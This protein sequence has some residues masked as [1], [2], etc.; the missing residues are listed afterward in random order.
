MVAMNMPKAVASAV[1]GCA[2]VSMAPQ[3][4]ATSISVKVWEGV[5]TA[6][7]GGADEQ[8]RPSN[9]LAGATPNAAFTYTFSG[10]LSWVETTQASNTLS[11]N[12]GSGG[13]SIAGCVGTSCNGATGL[14][15]DV[16]S[17]SGFQRTSLF[18]L[19]FTTSGPTVGVIGHDDGASIYDGSNTTAYY[20][21]PEP[22][23]LDTSVFS[24]PAA[25]TYNI[26]YVEANG[27]PS[28]LILNLRSLTSVPEPATLGLM[29]LGLIGIGFARRGRKN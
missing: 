2:L 26:W 14:M 5:N 29:G 13:G 10:G 9:P 16:L 11:A 22:T 23:V 18:E 21:D 3:A 17:T 24:L 6:G 20:Y 27:A 1:L 7:S 19:T 25:G 28:D 4:A 15:S 12:V 8:A